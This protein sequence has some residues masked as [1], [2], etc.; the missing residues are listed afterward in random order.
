MNA[1]SSTSW[2]DA[3]LTGRYQGHLVELG[4]KL[5]AAPTTQAFAAL[6]RAAAKDG[7]AL[8]IAS[9][10]R[11]FGRQA[12]IFNGKWQGLRPVHNDVGRPLDLEQMSEEQ[13]LEAI[14]RFSALPGASRHHWGTDLDVYCQEAQGEQPLALS[15]QEYGP[16]GPQHRLALWLAENAGSQGFFLPYDID[17][18]GVAVE[19]WHLS[20]IEAVPLLERLTEDKLAVALTGGQV[21]G[22]EAILP[23]LGAL[24]ARYVQRVGRP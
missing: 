1:S 23:R 21:A 6:Q 13:K 11:D 5:L 24:L 19:P 17:R 9:G 4:G 7:F 16:G 8:A 12:A 15:P 20:H 22:L 18:D 10:F 3:V 14:L 2:P